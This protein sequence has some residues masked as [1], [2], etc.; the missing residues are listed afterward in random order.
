MNL[1]GPQRLTVRQGILGF[2]AAEVGFRSRP[3]SVMGVAAG[4]ARARRRSVNRPDTAPAAVSDELRSSPDGSVTRVI[5][6]LITDVQQSGV[7]RA[8]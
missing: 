2:G 4:H 5:R 1:P 7:D 6:I 3:I 8:P